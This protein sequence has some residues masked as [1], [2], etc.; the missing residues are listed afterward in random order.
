MTDLVIVALAGFL[1]LGVLLLRATVEHERAMRQ[2][3]ADHAQ[4]IR[5]E[6][7]AFLAQLTAQ[8][9]EAIQERRSLAD[10]IQHPDHIQVIPS[11]D[12]RAPEPPKDEG[13]M[14]WVGQ[15]VP[16]FVH[17]GHPPGTLPGETP[18]ERI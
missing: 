4:F 14:A 10:R 16:E 13:E 3:L 12:Y 18:P 17:V 11:A 9:Q 6:R 15:M 2:L 1:L 8:R 7:H 5:D